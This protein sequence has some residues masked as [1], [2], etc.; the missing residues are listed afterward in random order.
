LHRK[1]VTTALM[2]ATGMVR[3]TAWVEAPREHEGLVLE[4]VKLT[5]ELGVDV[6]AADLD[7]RTALDN[8]K[9]LRYDS[10]VKF[11]LEN[12][13]KSAKPAPSKAPAE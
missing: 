11:L 3:A 9:T 12:G 1:N 4:A 2:A 13:A 5:T 8:A 10:V 6:N 7:G